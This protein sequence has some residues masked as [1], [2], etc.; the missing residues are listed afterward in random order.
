MNTA[1]SD[2]ANICQTARFFTFR[3]KRRL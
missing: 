2:F 3:F 1:N